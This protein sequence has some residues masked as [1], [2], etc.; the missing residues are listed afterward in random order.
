MNSSVLIHLSTTT[1]GQGWC[2]DLM[3][4]SSTGQIIATGWGSTSQQVLGPILSA[5]VW[6][7]VASTY[8]P[9]N[10][11]RLYV[12]GTLVG[13]TGAMAYLASGQVNLLTLGNSLQGI[14]VSSGGTCSSQSIVPNVYSGYVDEFRVYS[15]E[16]NSTDIARLSNP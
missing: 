13:S 5:N 4:F 12:N 3:G 15:R 1:I 14:P 9:T 2:V 16:L 10:G 11:V 6:T 7:H 8:S